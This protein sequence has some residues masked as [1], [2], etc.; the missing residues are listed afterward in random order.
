LLFFNW[1]YQHNQWNYSDKNV[2]LD[3]GDENVYWIKDFLKNIN[4]F[5]VQT[6]SKKDFI[7]HYANW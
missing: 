1:K 5:I 4:G 3:L 6:V 7:L 2:F